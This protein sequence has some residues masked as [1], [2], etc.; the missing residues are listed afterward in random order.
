MET[1]IIY[2]HSFQAK[3]FL[4][5]LAYPKCSPRTKC[6]FTAT[7][8]IYIF[9]SVCREIL[10]GKMLALHD[11]FLISSLAAWLFLWEC[12]MHAGRLC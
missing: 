7:G 12:F 5:E 11:H 9:T 6:S 8:E 4:P 10:H 1:V 2:L 3:L